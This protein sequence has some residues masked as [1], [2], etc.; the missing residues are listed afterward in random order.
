[1]A[2]T[3][4]EPS[5]EELWRELT[6]L[7]RRVQALE[8]G[9]PRTADGSNLEP[10][11]AS[12]PVARKNDLVPAA[13]SPQGRPSA[14]ESRIGAQLFNRVGVFAVL[15]GAAWFLKLAIDRAWIGPEARV[16]IGLLAALGLVV[17]SERFRRAGSLSF[18]YTLKAL[19]AGIA[20]LSLW[21]SFSLFHL[22]PAAVVFAAMVA[23]TL[24]NAVLAWR[25]GSELLA[26]LALAGGLATP[27]LLA[28]GGDQ[29]MFLFSYLLL[30]DAGAVALVAFRPWPRLA[31]GAFAGTTGYFAFWWLRY[32]T[33]GD[34]LPT[35]VFIVLFF[36][37]FTIAPLLAFRR[38]GSESPSLFHRFL[39]GFPIA[40][41]LCAFVE[42]RGLLL[43]ISE[44]SIPWIAVALGTIY[45][46][47]TVLGDRLSPDPDEAEAARVA[48]HL[49][50]VH[51][52]LTVGFFAL[53]A[54]L[55]F[56][57]YGI[58]LCWLAELLVLTAAAVRFGNQAVAGPLRGCAVAMLALAW[59]GLLV[60]NEDDHRIGGTPVFANI[61]FATSL[62][63]LA[64]FAAVI[65][66]CRRRMGRE[67]AAS[68]L[69]DVKS[70]L[71]DSWIFLAGFAAI[72]FSV[73]ALVAVSAQ[74][75]L[76]W[77]QQLPLP[78]TRPSA[79]RPAYV[80]FTYSAWFMLYGAALM[81]VGFLRRSAFLRWQALLLLTLS[82]GKVFLFDT[83]HLNEGYRVASFLGLGVLLLAVSFVYQRDWL[84]LRR[85]AG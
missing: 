18:S 10:R 7:K 8:L 2:G 11:E 15:A 73:V 80:D 76:Y 74:I 4:P 42:G 27:A 50:V 25:Q 38:E 71:L 29:E 66:L 20:Y 75:D 39:P 26:A 14:L 64:V 28:T 6:E 1:M 84:A 65:A 51:L 49:R 83:S 12:A 31:I 36:L 85:D 35:G 77:H 43:T 69:P 30:L 13:D 55:R 34:A 57:D 79:S 60:F 16:A 33:V 61:R 47:L 3:S 46:A 56:H 72:A 68:A 40:V 53:A 17:W 37:L 59:F 82:I 58:A 19:A 67:V 81:T 9:L 48:G 41:G 23:V 44:P 32:H 70:L 22:L 21:A 45:L 62:A 54:P 78:T 52:S 5:P 63:G 24:T